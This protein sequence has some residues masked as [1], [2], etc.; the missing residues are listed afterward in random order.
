MDSFFTPFP[1]PQTEEEAAAFVKPFEDDSS[2]ASSKLVETMFLP[3]ADPIKQ[4]RI[5]ASFRQADK[6]MAI[7]ALRDVIR[8]LQF[9]A[10][11]RLADL[12]GRLRNINAEP[13]SEQKPVRDN[14]V[15]VHGVG[16]FVPQIKPQAFNQ[17]LEQI[18][19]ELVVQGAE[20][21]NL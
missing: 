9:D 11:T 2:G 3:G 14:V 7:Q 17:A 6:T 4:E 13:R 12:G 5:A 1:I 8:W 20:T 15:L 16:H 10:E 21:S 18:I 19:V